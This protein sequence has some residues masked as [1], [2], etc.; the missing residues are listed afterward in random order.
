[1]NKVAMFM[2]GLPCSGKSTWYEQSMKPALPPHKYIN[3]D[4]IKFEF[5]D[6]REE[7]ESMY[8]NEAIQMAEDRAKAA[9]DKGE[10][11]VFDAGAI[12]G[13]YTNGL[14]Q[15]A[16]NKGYY[17]S[18]IFVNT[19]YEICM[20]R[21]SKRKRKVPEQMILDKEI[22]KISTWQGYT[23]SKLVDHWMEIPYFTEEHLFLDMDGVL[24]VQSDL[25]VVNGKIDFVNSNHFRHL[26]VVPQTAAI[27]NEL[28]KN[29]KKTLYILSAAPTSISAREKFSWLKEH[30]PFIKVENI[31]FV[32]SGKYKAEM[33]SDLHKRLKLDPRTT[34]LVEDTHETIKE[35]RRTYKMHSIH[36]SEFL[37]KY[38]L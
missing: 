18:M 7:N 11:V 4:D 29:P 34:C 12:N 21:N 13:K 30:F 19:P 33:F 6:Y 8:A 15:Y 10:N 32:N 37:Q 17:V 23:K 31:F 9:F 25:P 2:F 14:L 3:A 28:S 5:H 27:V 20:E 26:G 24:A 35:V 16:K 22:K 1:M 36:V 38:S